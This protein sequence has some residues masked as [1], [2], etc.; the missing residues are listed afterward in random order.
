VNHLI[1][2]GGDLTPYDGAD[3]THKTFGLAEVTLA[4]CLDNNQKYIVDFILQLL[5][6]KPAIQKKSNTAGEKN[7]QLFHSFLVPRVYFADELCPVYWGT[8]DCFRRCCGILV[9]FHDFRFSRHSY[10]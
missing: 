1:N 10:H 4:N 5:R 2:V 8:A 7:V 3:K 9:I 6:T